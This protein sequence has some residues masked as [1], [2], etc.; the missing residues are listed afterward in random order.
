M[1]PTFQIITLF[2]FWFML[3]SGADK[4]IEM[5][6]PTDSDSTDDFIIKREQYVLSY[7]KNLN[8]A[9]W[10]AWNENAE[11]YGDE[12]RCNC[13]TPDPLL[14]RSFTKITTRDYTGSGGYDRGHIL[15]SEART[16]NAKDNKSTF[17]MSNVL[18]QRKELNRGAW[19]GLEMFQDS[20]CTK[21]NKELYVIAGGVYK[22]KK[23]LKGKITIPD[24]CWKILVV[25]EQGQGL[26]DVNNNTSVIAV[27]MANRVYTKRDNDWRMYKTSVDNIEAATGYDF[28]NKLPVPLQEYIEKIVR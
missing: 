5:G 26:S 6:L 22:T 27:M 7:N 16:K 21:A 3:S 2:T 24:S 8:V 10:V 15:G 25:M 9:N 28:L 23:R 14:P 4:H 11:W 12:P 20:L 18:P 1:H 17:F 19:L 13:F